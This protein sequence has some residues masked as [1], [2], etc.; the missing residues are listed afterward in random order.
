[1]SPLAH[2]TNIESATSFIEPVWLNLAEAEFFEENK[3]D[4]IPL[5]TEYLYKINDNKM[6]FNFNWD[7]KKKKQFQI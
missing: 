1:M 2:F 6:Y 4:K 3:L 7:T 5:F